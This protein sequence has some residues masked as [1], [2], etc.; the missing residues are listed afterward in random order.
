M[1]LER[2]AARAFNR[3][4]LLDPAYGMPLIGYL[5]QRLNLGSIVDANGVEHPVTEIKANLDGYA[6]RVR[7]SYAVDGGIAVIPI[8]GTL[9]HKSGYIGSKS[10]MTGYDGIRA[11]LDDA[12]NNPAVLGI[13]LDVDSGGGEVSG[14]QA[15]A[16]KI[17]AARAIKPIWAHANEMAASAAYWTASSASKLFLAETSNVGSIGVL[18]AHRDASKRLESEGEKV[19]LIYS[20]AHKVDGNPYGELPKKVL[21]S[22]QAELDE[23][24]LL[25]STAVAKNRGMDVQAVLDTEAQVYRGSA[26]VKIGLADGVASFEAAMDNFRSFLSKASTAGVK[27][28]VV[29]MTNL[30]ET[31][32]QAGVSQE[33]LDAA[34]AQA[35]AE[36]LA[37]GAKSERERISAILGSEQAAGR[38]ETALRLA[39]TTDLTAEACAGIL[40]SVPVA[41]VSA[42]ASAGIEIGAG[43]KQSAAIETKPMHK[44]DAMVANLGVK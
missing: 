2:I 18:T 16:D 39:T 28:G 33:Q 22:I 26:A 17:F 19:T 21:D 15:L 24:R 5:T 13:M 4:L 12:I 44:L 10:G 41:T 9:V 29:G 8:E 30:N 11:Q 27:K 14:V 37:Q 43:V 32:P 3:P 6:S 7:S 34:V 1:K 40:A 36:G 25:F 38:S 35:H 23:L 42:G 31:Q 20:G